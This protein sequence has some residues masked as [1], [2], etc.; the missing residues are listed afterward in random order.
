MFDFQFQSLDTLAGAT[1]GAEMTLKDLRGKPLLNSRGGEIRFVLIGIDSPAYEALQIAK[2][3]SENERT[4]AKANDDAIIA[5][6][7][8]DNKVVTA[9]CIK[10]WS[11]V[12][13][14]SGNEIP[15]S[16]D[17]AIELVQK[18]P[19]IRMQLEDFIGD[20]ANFLQVSPSV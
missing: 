17:A 11:G 18:F 7:V 13:D 4:A 12:L 15:F 5:G 2:L 9:K 8:A 20:R 3:R 19:A 1:S 14:S 16:V 6:R 10:S